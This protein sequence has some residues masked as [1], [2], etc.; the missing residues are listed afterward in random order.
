[1]MFLAPRQSYLPTDN[2]AGSD[3]T[4]TFIMLGIFAVSLMFTLFLERKPKGSTARAVKEELFG[5]LPEFM[6]MLTVISAI[7]LIFVFLFTISGQRIEQNGEMA[8]TNKSNLIENI[9]TIYDVEA[10]ERVDKLKVS[11][12][13]ETRAVVVQDGVGYEVLVRQD[14]ETYEPELV[15]FANGNSEIA[16]IRKK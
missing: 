5:R 9:K 4:F 14:A 15:M 11:P 16:E 3:F 2:V 10:V 12:D 1:M 6:V 8:E 7:V 13:S